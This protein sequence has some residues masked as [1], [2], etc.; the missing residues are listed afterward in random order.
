MLLATQPFAQL[1]LLDIQFKRVSDIFGAYDYRNVA[2]RY[3]DTVLDMTMQFPKSMFWSLLSV[4]AVI[5]T[6][7]GCNGVCFLKS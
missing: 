1:E 4:A 5:I 2:D 7:A 6:V 3:P